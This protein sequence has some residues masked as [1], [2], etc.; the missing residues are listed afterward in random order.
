MQSLQSMAIIDVL[1]KLGNE[2]DNAKRLALLRAV[3]DLF[4]VNAGGYSDTETVLFDDVLSRL[5]K[6]AEEHIRQ[7]LAERMSYSEHAPRGLITQLANDEVRV[8]SPVLSHSPVLTDEDL[9]SIASN[10]DQAHMLAISMRQKLSE[11]VTDVLVERGD[12]N[13][14]RT[15]A[16]NTGALFSEKG[17]TRLAERASDDEELQV[18]LSERADLPASVVSE[19]LKTATERVRERLLASSNTEDAQ[20]IDNALHVAGQNIAKQIAPAIDLTSAMRFVTR[21]M[22]EGTL[23]EDVLYNVA[24][25]KSLEESICVLS[26]LAQIDLD[27]AKNFMTSKSAEAILL[28]S[29]A[30]NF[31]PAT[32]AALLSVNPT[33]DV[34][35]A[36]RIDYLYQYQN[37]AVAMA[38]R[39]VR[40]WKVRASAK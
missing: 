6:D 35:D 12:Q 31:K 21:L 8:A 32:V 3:T 40:F 14:A 2:K 39:I 25:E 11:A 26:A 1:E 34:T 4:F 23:N 20:L 22:Q 38:Q 5:A 13:V 36:K 17:Y 18:N 29:K 24:S 27:N 10:K 19:L 9:V 28:V 37:M 33:L 7:E 16:K 30:N 15:V